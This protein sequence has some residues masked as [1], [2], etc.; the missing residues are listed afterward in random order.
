MNFR[1]LIKGLKAR[2]MIARGNTPGSRVAESQAL[3]GR[4]KI[5]LEYTVSRIYAALTGL[6]L[7]GG[8]KPGALPRAIICRPDRAKE[9]G[10]GK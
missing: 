8:V 10:G 4:N 7:S 1:W 5:S 2:Q 9:W 3:K 6:D